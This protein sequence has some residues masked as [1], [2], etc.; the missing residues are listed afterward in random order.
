M[1]GL[2]ESC[3]E[4]PLKH[5]QQGGGRVALCGFINILS[6]GNFLW[7]PGPGCSKAGYR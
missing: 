7:N 4:H 1:A 3:V 5:A 6:N 2:L